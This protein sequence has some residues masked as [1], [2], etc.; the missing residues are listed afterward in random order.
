MLT[1]H[2]RI[3]DIPRIIPQEVYDS[4]RLPNDSK[5]YS[6]FVL[7]DILQLVTERQF[8]KVISEQIM[9]FHLAKLNGQV[10]SNKRVVP[11]T[12]FPSLCFEIFNAKVGKRHWCYIGNVSA[13]KFAIAVIF[14]SC[15]ML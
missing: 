5:Q 12:Q 1:Q 6:L 8:A 11:R 15:S 2:F 3:L 7:I 14:M 10:A 4:E 13:D 9:I